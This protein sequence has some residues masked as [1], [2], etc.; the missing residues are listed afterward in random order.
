M[1][2]HNDK[3]PRELVEDR[4]GRKGQRSMFFISI[5]SVFFCCIFTNVIGGGD[6]V[7][8]ER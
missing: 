7:Q 8:Y 2:G 5:F 1:T 6:G 3:E 4:Q